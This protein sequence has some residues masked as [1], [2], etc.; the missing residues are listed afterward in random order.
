MLPSPRKGARERKTKIEI[1]CDSVAIFVVWC[2][3]STADDDIRLPRA[4]EY[5]CVPVQLLLS[6]SHPGLSHIHIRYCPFWGSLELPQAAP[7]LHHEPETGFKGKS[8]AGCPTRNRLL[9]QARF[10]M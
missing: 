2:L 4:P 9:V 5:M 6:L 3:I 7:S 10:F 8:T 1:G